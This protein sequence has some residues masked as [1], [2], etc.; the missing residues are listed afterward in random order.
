MTDRDFLDSNV[1][2]YAYN[3][4]EPGKQVQ[5]QELLERAIQGETGVLSVQVL[6]EFF[7]VVTK[8]IPSP[9]SIEDAGEVV[10]LLAILPVISLDL[11][12][13]RRAIS[14]HERYGITYWDS[15]IVAAAERAGC[16]RIISED[17]NS[18]QSYLGIMAV[19]PFLG[20]SG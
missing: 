17:L 10:D 8:R 11:S 20:A 19:N 14:A 4:G 5:A 1:L 16:T 3:R 9:L 12:M 15:L 13:V 18:G 6:G 7:T 2:V